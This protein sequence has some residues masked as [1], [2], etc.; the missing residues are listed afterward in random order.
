VRLAGLSGVGKTRLVQALFDH[1]L[2]KN[3]LDS[4]D[5]IYTD[6]ADDP[7]PDPIALATQLIND[8][9]RAILI[10]DNCPP[11][12]HSRLTQICSSAESTLSLLTV[13]YDVRDDVPE[14]TSVFRLEPA[15]E[16]IIERLIRNRSS[17]ISQ[18]DA[19]T[20]AGFSGGNARVAIS[21]ANTV[22]GGETLSRLRSEE[23]FERLF[24]PGFLNNLN[25]EQ[26]QASS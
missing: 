1:R 22:T 21:L 24:A 5:A 14:N 7:V 4:N 9:S 13:E 25:N 2:G 19:R 8:K 23:L 15:S 6:V 3:A 16:K 26:F 18:V 10:I 11:D 17:H 20:I 12:L